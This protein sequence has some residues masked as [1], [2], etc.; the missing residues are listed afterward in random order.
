MRKWTALVLIALMLLCLCACGREV[1]PPPALE[2]RNLPWNSSP[3][4]VFGALDTEGAMLSQRETQEDALGAHFTVTARN[5]KVFGE[6]AVNAYFR[7]YNFT[8]ETGDY[9]GLGSVQIFY[10]EDCNEKV[11]LDNLR[12]LYGPEAQE[13]TLYSIVNGQ[14]EERQYTWEEGKFSWYSQK[15]VGDLL[16]ES[17]KAVYRSALGDITDEGFE[18]CLAAPA[19]RIGWCED[20]YGQFESPEALAT[21]PGKVAWLNFDGMIV[22]LMQQKFANPQ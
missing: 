7:F 11:V 15:L 2:F 6:T 9:F 10:P 21:E 20:Y 12:K 3:E 17:G 13:Y 16:S 4:A 14:P 5:W 22:A 1:Q 18:A 8:P 19:A